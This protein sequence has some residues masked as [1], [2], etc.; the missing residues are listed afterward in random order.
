MKSRFPFA[1]IAAALLCA[2]FSAVVSGCGGVYLNEKYEL[3]DGTSPISVEN[4]SGSKK[5]SEKKYALYVAN[6]SFYSF[7]NNWKSNASQGWSYWGELSESRTS[8]LK[9]KFT[10]TSKKMTK[11]E[12]QS[13]LT[14]SSEESITSLLG[15]SRGYLAYCPQNSSSVKIV[16]KMEDENTMELTKVE[17]TGQLGMNIEWNNYGYVGD[18]VY[19]FVD[20]AYEKTASTSAGSATID[21]LTSGSHSV[22]LKNGNSSDAKELSNSCSVY[23]QAGTAMYPYTLSCDITSSTS[24]TLSWTGNYYGDYVY[25]WKNGS[26]M[27]TNRYG[28]SSS[29]ITGLTA[30]STYTFVLRANQTSGSPAISNSV[31]VTMPSSSSS[32]YTTLDVNAG[33][34]EGILTSGTQSCI[35]RFYASAGRTYT[36][37]WAD[38]YQGTGTGNETLDVKVS[39]YSN[40]SFVSTMF[41]DSTGQT[42]K[43][44]ATSGYIYLKVEP[45]SSGSTGTFKIKVS[46]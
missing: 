12:I 5:S 9:S 45:Y 34:T 46:S 41:F 40:L 11:E 39:A 32:S 33:W 20:G 8:D 14:Y 31:T 4:G 15:Y 30:G 36:V 10:F 35:Y 38:S 17:D 6:P 37:Y 19:I 24:V 43:C 2:A 25:V 27:N 26:C 23:I 29:T 18:S 42:I 13:Y 22:V 1:K 16:L 28:Y 21:G 7:Q 3:L 44:G